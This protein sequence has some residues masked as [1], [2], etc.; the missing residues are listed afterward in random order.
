[1]TAPAPA[2]MPGSAAT[3]ARQRYDEAKRSAARAA[4][5]RRAVEGSKGH[6][7]YARFGNYGLFEEELR[8]F[9]IT[10][11]DGHRNCVFPSP[12]TI[13]SGIYPLSTQVLMTTTVSALK[14]EEVKDFLTHYLKSA[15]S[16]A[17]EAAMVELTDEKLRE[18][19]QWL[20]GIHDPVLV[21]PDKDEPEAEPDETAETGAPAR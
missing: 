5:A 15:Q 7:I 4:N 1:M 21:V 9:E 19:L 13:A 6:L 10:S 12:T 8:P 16:A 20:D 3:T 2:A 18:E 14:R 17:R 11:P